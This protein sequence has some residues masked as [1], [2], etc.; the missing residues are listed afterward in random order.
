M[1]TNSIRISWKATILTESIQRPRWFRRL[2]RLK[3]ILFPRGTYGIM[4]VRSSRPI[5]DRRS[6][7]RALQEHRAVFARLPD[8]VAGSPP[9]WNR[10]RSYNGSHA[11]LELVKD[12]HD[13]VVELGD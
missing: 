13:E 11:F 7:E 1:S 5:G 6:I 9:T 2:E 12:V 8:G 4:Q 10:L 3:G